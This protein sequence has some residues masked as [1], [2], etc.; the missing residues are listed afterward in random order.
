[1]LRDLLILAFDGLAE[2]L[3]FWSILDANS[4]SVLAMDHTIIKVLKIMAGLNS[5]H[6]VGFGER[7]L[8][9]P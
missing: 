3:Q 2:F 6:K 1:M 7:L 9:R 8:Y 4:H 5:T